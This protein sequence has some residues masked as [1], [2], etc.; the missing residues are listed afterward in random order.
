MYLRII[1]LLSI[2]LFALPL[3]QPQGYAAPANLPDIDSYSDGTN[4]VRAEEYLIDHLYR[5]NGVI[6]LSQT[7]LMPKSSALNKCLLLQ[8][9]TLGD[10]S[11]YIALKTNNIPNNFYLLLSSNVPIPPPPFASYLINYSSKST[12]GYDISV[13]SSTSLTNDLPINSFRMG[14]AELVCFTN[15]LITIPI[16][17]GLF[18]T[19]SLPPTKY[20]TASV[21]MTKPVYLSDI[22]L[23]KYGQLYPSDKIYTQDHLG[24]TLSKMNISL[25]PQKKSTDLFGFL[26]RATYQDL[27]AV[28]DPTLPKAAASKQAANPAVASFFRSYSTDSNQWILKGA[29]FRPITISS[30][31]GGGLLYLVPSVSVDREFN[32]ETSS[33]SV[34]SLTF[35]FGSVYSYLGNSSD[36]NYGTLRIS[37]DYATDTSFKSLVAAAESDWEPDLAFFNSRGIFP[38]NELYSPLFGIES[39]YCPKIRWTTTFHAEFGYTVKAGGKHQL[40]GDPSALR[41]GPIATISILPFPAVTTLQLNK[42]QIS[43]SYE[44]LREI[45]GD[46]SDSDDF[47][48]QGTYPMFGSDNVSLTM[49]YEN[50]YTPIVKDRIQSLTLGIGIKF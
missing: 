23:G 19:S 22:V 5:T 38:G 27:T 3:L 21:D 17:A 18:S 46:P 26:V 43:L 42:F 15:K 9:P 48:I 49:A 12:L 4:V 16:S 8:I 10:G 1:K 13:F 37:G 29:L 41:L 36:F 25:V 24:E 44:Y 7:Y 45:V 32:N 35:R 14:A 6:G 34:D 47:K 30:N 39:I 50:G 2:C 20:Y 40:A 33:N 31:L 11:T 28:E